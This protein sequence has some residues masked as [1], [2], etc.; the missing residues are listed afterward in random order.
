MSNHQTF[1]SSPVN[2][3]VK[4][5]SL[6]SAILFVFVYVDLFGF[7]RADFRAEIESGEIAGFTINETFL[8]AAVTYIA[9]PSLMVFLTMVLPP[10]INRITNIVLP[11]VYAVTI[12]ASAIG[13]WAYFIFG[14]VLE[15]ILLAV[16]AW[17][18][19]TWPRTNAAT[20]TATA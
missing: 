10:A 7:F 12:V 4:I 1:D 16:I 9:L 15:L 11:A 17:F 6:W 20:T 3:R 18:A 19:W 14:S 13:E 5:S 8:M 2:I